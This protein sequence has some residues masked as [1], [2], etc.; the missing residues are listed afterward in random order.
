MKKLFLII[1]AILFSFSILSCAN[2]VDTSNWISDFSSAKKAAVKENKKIFLFFSADDMDQVSKNL[3]E[4]VFNTED[5]LKTYTEKYILVNL[6]FSDSRYDSDQDG[7]QEDMKISERYNIQTVP[8]FFILSKEGYVI[9]TLAF[10]ASADFDTVKITFSEAGETVAKFDENLAK[11]QTGTKEERLQAI[12][13]IYEHTNPQLV[14]H[15]TP[16]NQ[17]YLSLDKNNESGNCSR[18]LFAISYAKC[19]DFM[20]DNEQ[21]KVP[22]EFASLAKNKLLSAEEKQMAFYN[23]GYFLAQSGSTDYEK[24]KDYFQKAYDAAPETEEA[25]TL[26]TAITRLQMMIDGE[27][28]ELTQESEPVEGPAAAPA[29]EAAPAAE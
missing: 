22:E 10:D 12:N 16:L 24:I 8:Y 3:K 4:N 26:Q 7:L 19:F 1:I 20:L 13:D 2:N 5:F 15:L 17:L 18:H 11:T 23:A 25:A 14:Y 9:T 27:G 28:D 6:D 21:Q 29:E